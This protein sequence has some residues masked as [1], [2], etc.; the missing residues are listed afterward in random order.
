[1]IRKDTAVLLTQERPGTGVA[2]EPDIVDKLS[3]WCQQDEVGS[4]T[5]W[6]AQSQGVKLDMTIIIWKR[7]RREFTHATIGGK[8][9]QIAHVGKAKDPRDL[10]LHLV[11]G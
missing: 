5:Y 4:V 6:S 10:K 3:T 11:R 9:Y 1:M 8:K 2:A 7:E